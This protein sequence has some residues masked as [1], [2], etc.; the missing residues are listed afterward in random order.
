MCGL[1]RNL[2][3]R[4]EEETVPFG[5][6]PR[7]AHGGNR[8]LKMRKGRRCR[9]ERSQPHPEGHG[10]PKKSFKVIWNQIL[11]NPSLWTEMFSSRAMVLKL[12]P[13]SQFLEDLLKHRLLG[14]TLRASNSVGQ[15]Q[16]W[17]SAFLPSSRGAML[18]LLTQT[19]EILLQQVWEEPRCLYPLK[20]CRKWLQSWVRKSS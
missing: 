11:S 3:N 7:A 13:E 4:G 14:P 5:E 16:G 1:T 20:L 17:G 12:P 15:G 18:M 6:L 10:Y 8:E 9:K 2:C 19:L